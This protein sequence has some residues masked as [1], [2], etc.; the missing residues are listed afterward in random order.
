VDNEAAVIAFV[1]KHAA[2]ARVFTFGA[3]AAAAAGWWLT[4]G[5]R[6]RQRGEPRPGGRH[7]ARRPRRGRVHRHGRAVRAGARGR[8]G[9]DGT[10]PRSMDAQVMRQLKRA[11][12]PVY[13][14]VRVPRGG[15][16]PTG[17]GRSAST[18]RRWAP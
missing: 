4:G 3:P 1:R 8:G 13:A 10:P 17:G 9:R 6:D 16:A 15:A 2:E 18:G 7:G 5:A 14:D 11:L 12:Q